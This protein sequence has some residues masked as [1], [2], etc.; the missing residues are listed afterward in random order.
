[1]TDRAADKPPEESSYLEV[2]N[3]W[4]NASA[5]ISS[6]VAPPRR[7]EAERSTIADRRRRRH[8]R[9]EEDASPA[10]AARRSTTRPRHHGRPGA[11][12]P[13]A[14]PLQPFHPLATMAGHGKGSGTAPPCHRDAANLDIL[15]GKI[16]LPLPA[17]ASDSRMR[18]PRRGAGRTAPPDPSDKILELSPGGSR[19]RATGTKPTY[20]YYVQ[21]E[22]PAK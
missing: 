4:R 12:P 17:S 16:Q 10:E 2:F 3:A 13:H 1:M 18:A 7:P 22:T 8:P 14:T 20:Y 11:A 6:Y 5:E 15:L 9:L 19:P 21:G